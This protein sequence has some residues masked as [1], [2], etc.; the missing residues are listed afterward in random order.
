MKAIIRSES[1]STIDRY[2]KGKDGRLSAL[3]TP[4]VAHCVRANGS[5]T[6]LPRPL[7]GLTLLRNFSEPLLLNDRTQ[8]LQTISAKSIKNYRSI[9]SHDI[10]DKIRFKRRSLEPLQRFAERPRRMVP[11]PVAIDPIDKK[12]GSSPLFLAPAVPTK[13]LQ[14]INI[15]SGIPNAFKNDEALLHFL[16]VTKSTNIRVLNLR[17]MQFIDK[18]TLCQLPRFAPA[19]KSLGLSNLKVVDD[20]VFGAVCQIKS[21]TELDCSG[22]KISLHGLMLGLPVTKNLIT[23]RIDRCVV[24]PN[25]PLAKTISVLPMLFGNN[26][27]LRCLSISSCTFDDAHFQNILKTTFNQ[28]Q[29]SSAWNE[30]NH[31]VLEVGDKHPENSIDLKPDP[32][33]VFGDIRSEVDRGN[34]SLVDLKEANQS[35]HKNTKDCFVLIPGIEGDSRI[36]KKIYKPPSPRLALCKLD[37]SYNDN[38]SCEAILSLLVLCPDMHSLKLSC[39]DQITDSAMKSIARA[40]SR[41]ARLDISGCTKVTDASLDH[42]AFRCGM[43]E[44][45][46]LSGCKSIKSFA[47]LENFQSLCTLD[48]GNTMVTESDLNEILSNGSP[49]LTKLSLLCTE[50]LTENFI[51][52]ILSKYQYQREGF[53]LSFAVKSKPQSE[54]ERLKRTIEA[55]NTASAKRP[56]STKKEAKKQNGKKKEV[57][58][59]NGKKKTGGKKKKK[60]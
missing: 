38:I 30:Y 50:N 29:L 21:L 37:L 36:E 26:P 45:L 31:W 41:L 7:V 25:T 24:G 34:S 49:T 51:G 27:E 22:C 43:L 11:N 42:L 23:L 1:F 56:V 8:D 20:A 47:A 39:C 52:D 15:S 10:D 48:C 2:R 14:K 57:K 9:V 54:I 28:R 44:D 60:K 59:Q 35:N 3:G 32:S 33:L 19:L 13:S 18:R 55:L 17:D 16:S 53:D 46:C 12:A 40:C 5:Y 6:P 4:R 58:K